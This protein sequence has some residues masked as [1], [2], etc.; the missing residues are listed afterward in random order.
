MNLLIVIM[1]SEK[2]SYH[3]D[4]K[5][6]DLKHF[7]IFSLIKLAS[8]GTFSNSSIGNPLSMLLAQRILYKIK[9]DC[10]TNLTLLEKDI[11]YYGKVSGQLSYDLNYYVVLQ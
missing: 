5:L 9:N 6:L 1:L 11:A 4:V 8:I 10:Y 7:K 2:Y 3:F